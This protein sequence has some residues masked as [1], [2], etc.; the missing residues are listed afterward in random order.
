MKSKIRLSIFLVFVLFLV[1]TIQ[2]QQ[3]LSIVEI[4]GEN[5]YIY[6]MKK[7]ESL[8]SIARARN[9]DYE[10]L[11]RLNPKAIFSNE[12]G[13]KIYY[14]VK[15]MPDNKKTTET[16]I[17]ED[18]KIEPIKHVV[19]RG[20]SVY[21]ISNMYQIPIE[22]IY[23]LNPNS[24]NGIREG[25]TLTMSNESIINGNQN[26]YTIKRGDTLY[27]IAKQFQT[28]VAAIM[29]LNPGLTE[30]NCKA[31]DAL[32]VPKRGEGMKRKFMTVEKE[33]LNSIV[34]YKVEKQDTWESISKKTGV[35][36]DDLRDA[37]P[38]IENEP[39][40]KSIISIPQIETVK[41]SKEIVDSDLREM[42][43]EGR[44]QIYNE[45]HDLDV[46]SIGNGVNVAVVLADPN[47]KKDIEL[48]RG[49]LSALNKMKQSAIKVSLT[50]IDGNENSTTIIDKLSEINPDIVFTTS[51][52]DIP[53]YFSE[54]AQVSQTPVVN[55]F[56]IKNDFYI[57]NPYIIQLI[58]PSEYFNDAIAAYIK[59]HYKGYSL[60]FV[61]DIDNQDQ[62]AQS[63][64]ALWPS[65]NIKNLSIDELAQF[66]PATNNKYLIYGYPTKRNEVETLLSGVGEL[67]NKNSNT[68]I[69]LIGRPNWILYDEALGDKLS[70]A[71]AMI[72]SRFYFD[73]TSD[74]SK[75][76]LNH[77]NDLFDGSPVKSFPMY[78]ALGFDMTNYFL[79]G[80]NATD[81]DINRLPKMKEEGTQSTFELIRSS[82]WTG[83]INP[84][85][86][87]VK[88]NSD[89]SIE[90]ISIK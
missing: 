65:K 61:G 48:C 64:K 44:E 87:L 77:Y 28:T 85:V 54:Y 84:V 60:L 57:R 33:K 10:E 63:L 90:R 18:Q 68:S 52:K 72:P 80:I 71:S 2:S 83:M 62:F 27:G 17:L 22:K 67:K 34:P 14:P 7:G 43:S 46:D 29:K 32:R 21:A 38:D 37:N 39:K 8:F 26:F 56:D 25:E 50:V 42:T 4:L 82:N 9:W 41:T 53:T 55:V 59:K 3:K 89:K 11:Q 19:K 49:I 69:E 81:G 47:S 75:D 31:G 66:T 16:I 30:S 13:I 74:V 6:E 20:E 76:F 23:E 70:S 35:E 58:T 12:K 88:F 1:G 86:Y 5:Y 45:V 79:P 36:T 51:E 73:K 24:K 40:N 78:A 15:K